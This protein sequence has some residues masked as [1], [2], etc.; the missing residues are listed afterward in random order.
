MR[1]IP[2][3]SGGSI[4]CFGLGTWRMGESRASRRQEIDALNH[5]IKSGI[6]LIDT[7]EMY[8]EGG[9][10]TVMAEAIASHRAAL[11][12]VSKVYPH[13]ASRTGVIAACDRSLARLKTD[14]LDLY[15]LHWKGSYPVAETLE[16]FHR[17]KQSGKIRDFGVSNFDCEDMKQAIALPYGNEI[18]VNQVLYNLSRRG[19]EWDLLPWCQEHNI[20][21][22]AYSPLEQGRI[23][24][25]QTLKRIAQTRNA[26]PAQ[27]AI[28]WILRQP[29]VLTIP[30][31]SSPQRMDENLAALE[32]QLSEDE[33]EQLN[34]AFPPPL[35]ATPLAVL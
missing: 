1:M 2:L 24:H 20:P 12:L 27:I 25:N 16:A 34:Q 22:M 11:Y 13:H 7:A 17:L 6:T 9:A 23:L 21:V 30:K 4:P 35:R 28:A 3:R 31:S 26:T 18:A 29:G 15:L 10:E 19:I 14:Y 5:G 8:G 33:L 32:I